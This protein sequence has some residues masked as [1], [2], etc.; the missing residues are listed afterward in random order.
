M[1]QAVTLL[2]PQHLDVRGEISVGRDEM[3]G[4]NVVL[5]G[6]VVIEDDVHIV[7]KCVIR[8]SVLRRGAVIKA[9][10]HLEGAELGDV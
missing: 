1:R 2:D 8:D 7:P 3:I 10:S 4:V 5:G 6:R 9:N